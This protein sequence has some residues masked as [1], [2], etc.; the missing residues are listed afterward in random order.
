MKRMIRSI[1]IVMT[2]LTVIMHNEADALGSAQSRQGFIPNKGQWH[3]DILW[4]AHT[5]NVNVWITTKGY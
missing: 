4:F 2:L 5:D 1:V 3:S